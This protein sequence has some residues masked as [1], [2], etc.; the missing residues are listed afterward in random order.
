MKMQ[1]TVQRYDQSDCRAQCEPP[2]IEQKLLTQLGEHFFFLLL[3]F[4]HMKPK[5]Y[6]LASETCEMWVQLTVQSCTFTAFGALQS[7]QAPRVLA[8]PFLG[9]HRRAACGSAT[10]RAGLDPRSAAVT[11]PFWVI[12][13]HGG[14]QSTHAPAE[15]GTRNTSPPQIWV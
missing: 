10:Q 11:H 5:H 2:A 14:N 6:I 7:S 1:R 8:V 15:N 3:F 4:F 13:L 9:S 12:F